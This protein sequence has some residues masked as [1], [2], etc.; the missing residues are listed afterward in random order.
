MI[1]PWNDPSLKHKISA[2]RV[3]VIGDVMLDRTIEGFI[4]RISPEAPVP[5]MRYQGQYDHC[6]G[7][8]NTAHNIAS[9]E[10]GCLLLGIVGDDQE[11]RNL[12][13]CLTQITAAQPKERALSINTWIHTEPQRTT[14]LKQRFRTP[15]AQGGQQIF[16]LD[17]E[18]SHP[19]SQD[20]QQ[21]LITQTSELLGQVEA[22]VL[23]DYAKGLLNAETLPVLITLAKARGIP[24][25]VDP[26]PQHLEYYRGATFL[27][28]NRQECHAMLGHYPTDMT[29]LQQSI[30]T[31]CHQHNLGGVLLT[32][33]EEG[34]SLFER[35]PDQPKIMHHHLATKA[36]Q[37]FDVT[38]AGDTTCG[39][40]T[41]ALAAGYPALFAAEMAQQAAQV[42]ITKRGTHPCYWH[43]L[44]AS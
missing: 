10:A 6:G 26:V 20:S 41:T 28:P 15:L 11:G 14:T 24:V 34:L 21:W 12:Q 35:I 23:V 31:L 5:I 18:Q 27:S 44:S 43:E 17:H 36:Q 2:T 19:I 38:G 8:A 37:V 9:L 25:V 32:R 13:T 3:L 1:L 22:M 30:T 40:F 29:A 33:A 16:R 7:A 42:V 4:E 39:V